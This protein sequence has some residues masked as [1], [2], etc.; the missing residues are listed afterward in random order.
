MGARRV[1][2]RGRLVLRAVG[3]AG[4]YS[5]PTRPSWRAGDRP[6][7]GQSFSRLG[8]AAGRRAASRHGTAP[9]DLA[10][11]APVLPLVFAASAV[12]NVVWGT[13]WSCSRSAPFRLVG[14]ADAELP[15]VL[16]VHR[17][18]RA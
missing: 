11:P 7:A 2:L 15:R 8:G 5:D 6:G 3:F 13:A 17:D 16:A 18:V 10:R 14:M 1:V 9:H 12:Y 4:E